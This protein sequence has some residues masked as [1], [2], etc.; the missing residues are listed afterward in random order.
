M[1][2][3][4][5]L[6][7]LAVLMLVRKNSFSQD[8][9][10]SQFYAA[11]L[12]LNPALTGYCNGDWRAMG[13]YRSQW[14]SISVPYITQSLG[15]DHQ[16]YIYTENFSWGINYIN[17]KSGNIDLVANKFYLSFAYH[18]KLADFNS[19]HFGIQAGYVM[20]SYSLSGQTY[21]AQWD[22]TIGQFNSNLLSNEPGSTEQ[23]SYF[24]LNAGALWSKK[25]KR[26]EPQVGFAMYHLTQPKESYLSS[27]NQLPMR[28]VFHIEVKFNIT[29]QFYAAPKALF[30]NMQNANDIVA[31]ANIG[32][33]LPAN[34]LKLNS[35]WIGSYARNGYNRN[36]DAVFFVAGLNYHDFDIGFS[37]DLNISELKAATQSRGAFEISVIYTAPSTITPN[38]AIPCDRY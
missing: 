14:K 22:I 9:H 6:V 13:I 23:P 37:Y 18:K 12:A 16:W 25:F 15:F 11:P 26:F 7:F 8:I 34:F 10:F 24:D 38:K 27:N 30:M 4:F 28:Q 1:K 2:K 20:K 29:K 17:D 32:Y 35:F 21:P 3:Y 5:L 19:L 31:G 33:V 36:M